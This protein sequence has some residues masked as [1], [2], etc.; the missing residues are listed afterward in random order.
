MG[1]RPIIASAF[2]ARW[3]RESGGTRLS[4]SRF[5]VREANSVLTNGR[6]WSGDTVLLARSRQS[7]RWS[8]LRGKLRTRCHNCRCCNR[9]RRL[10]PNA[11]LN[12]LIATTKAH[13]PSEMA[14]SETPVGPGDQGAR[15][16]CPRQG[17]TTHT[18]GT[19]SLGVVDVTNTPMPSICTRKLTAL[20]PL[21]SN[22]STTKPAMIRPTNHTLECP[23][24]KYTIRTTS[25]IPPM[26]NPPPYPHRE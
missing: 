19:A 24:S 3:C 20:T 25:R 23:T 5:G 6:G 14:V 8:P 12:W 17:R 2:P 7:Q 4:I 15:S 10:G 26:P 1:P 11:K 16:D 9:P 13:D 21:G 22:R 18:P